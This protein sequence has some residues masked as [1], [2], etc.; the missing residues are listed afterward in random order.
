VVRIAEPP[1]TMTVLQYLREVAGRCGTKEGCAEGDCGA[2]TVV[3]GE[4]AADGSVRYRA[5]NSCIRFLPTLDGRELVTVED[6][7]GPDGPLHPVQQALVDHHASQCGFCSPGFV[8]SLF[9]L[10]LNQPHPDREQ[11]LDA[12]SG[13]LCRCTGYRPIIDAGLAM[14]RYGTPQRW[15]R[16]SAQAPERRAQLASLAEAAPLLAPD[17]RYLAPRSVDEL[18][19]RF[20]AAPDSLLL[21]GGT[22]IGLWVTQALLELPPLIWI[23]DVEELRRIDED[24]R[25]LRIGAAV[26]LTDA[27]AAVLRRFP[28]LAGQAERFASMPVRNSGT[29]VGNLANGSPIGDSLPAMLALDAVLELRC[30]DAVRELPLCEFYLDYRRTALGRGEFIT[31]VRIPPRR[32]EDLVASYKVS[33]RREQDISAVSATFRLRIED[34]IVQQVRLAYGGMAGIAKRATHA[35]AAITG[36]PW[37][38]ATLALARAA[39]AQDFAPLTDLRASGEYRLEVAGALLE[40]LLRASRGEH[41]ALPDAGVLAREVAP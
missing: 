31:A 41:V 17:G 19:A 27:W 35:E 40:R 20:A 36:S 18:A 5:V 2:C 25:G 7:A 34:G 28:E 1:P 10:Y 16:E 11:V 37:N 14:E 29:L 39:L 30:G 15:S 3:L 9:A 4:P 22:D 6:L 23:G 33:R 24:A 8:M 38:E 12:I 21:A 26:T 32:G 13:N